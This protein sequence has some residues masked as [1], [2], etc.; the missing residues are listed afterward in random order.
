MINDDIGCSGLLKCVQHANGRDWWFLQYT[1]DKLMS[2]LVSPSGITLS[3]TQ[4]LPYSFQLVKGGRSAYRPDGSQIAAYR[5]SIDSL[6]SELIIMDFDRCSGEVSE[7]RLQYRQDLGMAAFNNGVEYSPSGQYLYL[8]TKDT[9]FQFDTWASDVFSTE[10][11][12]MVWDSSYSQPPTVP[13]PVGQNKNSFNQLQRGPDNKIYIAGGFQ[14]YSMHI[15]HDP[16]KAGVECNGEVDA[17]RLKTYYTS[18]MPTFN[19]LRLGPI[20]GGA[21]D[22]LGIDNNPVSHFRYEQDSLDYLDLDFIDLSYYEPTEWEWDFG[23]GTESTERFPSHRYEVEGAYKVCLTV[24]NQF[25]SDMRCDT[26]Y[27]G[28]S[29]LEQVTAERHIS[30]FPNP[31]EDVTRVAFHDYLPKKA[32]IRFYD[33]QGRL[34]LI[35][36]LNEVVQLVDLSGLAAGAYVYEVWDGSKRLKIGKVV[37]I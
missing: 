2:F 12:V 34:V 17:I 5:F 31:V 35:E 11:A 23:D 27:L 10:Q 24:S 13:P 9:I 16:D 6:G 1:E 4:Q 21:C 15:I 20:D 29:S 19:T 7:V 3:H 28:V 32:N 37:R 18:T 33:L 8:S 36:N 22:T 30:L 14:G 25:S 26:L